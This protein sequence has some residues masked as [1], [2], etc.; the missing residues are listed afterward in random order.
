MKTCTKCKL[1]KKLEDFCKHRITKDGLSLMCRECSKTWY[2]N[3][4]DKHAAWGRANFQKNKE[5][6]KAKR[7]EQY[8]SDISFRIQCL[9]R[10]RLNKLIRGKIKNGSAVKDLG[11]SIEEFKF[12]LEKQ[13]LSGMN[14]SNYGI[15]KDKWNIDH[16][17]PISKFDL[18]DRNQFIKAN[19]YNNL[20]PMW[21]LDNVRKGNK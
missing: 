17:I 5:H 15:G 2:K 12:H 13:F 7:K 18:S 3:N 19:N 1:I 20:Q 4:K 8:R 16:I 14:W 10:N 11:C 9:L 21:H 6:V